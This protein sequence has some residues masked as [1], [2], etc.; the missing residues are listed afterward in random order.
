MIIVI[1]GAD[2]T[3]K[4]TLANSLAKSLGCEVMHRTHITDTPK[5]TLVDTYRKLLLDYKDKNLILDRAWYSE[6]CYGPVFRGCSHVSVE[7]MYALEELLHALGGFVIYCHYSKSYELSQ[8]RGEDYV[9]SRA[10]H[11]AVCEL[12]KSTFK[13]YKHKTVVLE[14]AI[15]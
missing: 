3:G 6:M 5:S 2:G 14:Y 8:A 12:Y 13:D 1:E 9:T 10:A 11:D 15:L 7:Q 4:S